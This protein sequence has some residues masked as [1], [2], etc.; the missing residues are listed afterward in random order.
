MYAKKEYY[1]NCEHNIAF[2]LKKME[3]HKFRRGKLI[4]VE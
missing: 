3:L 2:D 1:Y 4:L